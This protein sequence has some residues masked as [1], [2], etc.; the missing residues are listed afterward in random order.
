MALLVSIPL[1]YLFARAASGGAAAWGEHVFTSSTLALLRGTVS[2]LLGV[3]TLT[4]II[5]L[6]YAWLVTRSDLPGRRFWSVAGALPLVYPSYMAAFTLVAVLGPRGELAQILGRPIRE[7]AYGWSGALIALGLFSYPYLYLLLVARMKSIDPAQE[8]A[9]R[10]LGR[11]PANVFFSVFVP[12]LRAPLAAGLL[13][14]ALYVISD[15]GAVSIVRYDT[16]T[17]A[18]YDA[19]R[20]LFDRTVAAVLGTVLVALTLLILLVEWLIV[21]GL[22]PQ[23]ARPLRRST[24]VQLGGW[25]IPALLFVGGVTTLAMGIPLLAIGTWVVR[26]TVAGYS[27]LTPGAAWNSLSISLVTAV[28][29][30]ALSIPVAVWA[31]RGGG[32]AAAITE[33]LTFSG[34]ALPGIV[35]GLSL[36]F[37]TIRVAWPLYQTPLLL[38]IACTIRFVPEAIAATR[39]ALLSVAPALEDAARSLGS[40]PLQVFTR[41]TL[42]MI[43]PGL[44]AGAGL[45]F[46]TSIKEL[47][48]TLILRPAGFETLATRIW[49]EAG[50]SAW[51]GAAGPSLLLLALS[52]PPIWFLVIRPALG[53]RV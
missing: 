18:I 11:S 52:G 17:T 33:R 31:V 48:A 20:G 19:Y 2:I 21:R 6:P 16:F 15:F 51:S 4:T 9:A 24:P 47:P 53:E 36:V 40:G 50:V 34:Y 5:A 38:V 12:Q 45:V 3:L 26:G 10:T 37:L 32:S 46:L 28:V 30:V 27:A 1:V 8:E 35:V 22:A 41:V 23:S 39:S 7:F 25:K 42:P 14:V 13:L 44:L 49:S 29:A 43:R